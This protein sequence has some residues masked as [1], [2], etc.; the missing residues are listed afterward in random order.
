[1]ACHG[2]ISPGKTGPASQ[3]LDAKLV[4]PEQ[5]KLVAGRTTFGYQNQ[6]GLTKNGQTLLA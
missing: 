6:S 1:M 3:I 2:K 4:R 5:Q